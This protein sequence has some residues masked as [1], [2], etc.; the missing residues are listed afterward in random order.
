MTCFDSGTLVNGIQADDWTLGLT[1][2]YTWDPGT[3]IW[4]SPS[5]CTGRWEAT[6]QRSKVDQL[7]VSQPL[8]NHLS[9]S[10]Q[11]SEVILDHASSSQLSSCPNPVGA[12]L[13]VKPMLPHSKAYILNSNTILTSLKCVL[14]LRTLMR[15]RALTA[16]IKTAWHAG[17]WRQKFA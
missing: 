16:S 11:V 5:C 13:G 4:M 17:K 10:R 3:I 9:T 7:S 2:S 8:T 1:S 12:K 15:V 6:W 14:F